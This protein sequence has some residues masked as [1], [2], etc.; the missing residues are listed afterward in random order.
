[1][2]V[3]IMIVRESEE[4]EGAAQA[5]VGSLEFGCEHSELLEEERLKELILN[6]A[7]EVSRAMVNE[8]H[9]TPP[10][11]EPSN[12]PLFSRISNYS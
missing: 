8:T 9:W 6:S 11:V 10:N 4:E 7:V 1:M 2:I 5:L 3:Q 12:C